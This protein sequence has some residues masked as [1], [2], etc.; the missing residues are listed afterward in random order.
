MLHQ[1]REEAVS[2]YSKDKNGNGEDTENLLNKQDDITQ[3][4]DGKGLL[5]PCSAII[6]VKKAP[7]TEE[8]IHQTRC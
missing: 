1:R 3:R 2:S 4:G 5:A 7:P 6:T 8:G